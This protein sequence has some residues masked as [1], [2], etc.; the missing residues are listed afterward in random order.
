M[1]FNLLGLGTAVPATVVDQSDALVIARSLCCRT[2][3]QATW[4]PTMYHHTGIDRRH[5]ILGQGVVRDLLD[6]TTPSASPFLP[7]G[8]PDDCGPTTAERMRHYV[9]GAGPLALCAARQALERSG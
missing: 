4:L 7:T 6:G 1:S 5:L 2:E 3:E 9:A 8:A